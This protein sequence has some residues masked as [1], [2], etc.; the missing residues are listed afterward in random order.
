LLLVD[1]VLHDYMIGIIITSF[2]TLIGEVGQSLS[3]EE[4]HQ[5]RESHYELAF[6]NGLFG[7]LFFLTIVFLVPSHTEIG[8]QFSGLVFNIDSLPT[9]ITRL[10]L[11]I[12]LI[13]LII[14]GLEKA[15][16]A[17]FS[18]L[19]IL[20]IPFLVVADIAL[21]FNISWLEILG[22]GVILTT[23]LTMLST[24]TLRT[25]GAWHVA[26]GSLLA[27]FTI[28]LYQYNITNFNSIAGEQLMMYACLGTYLGI[29]SVY[30]TRKNPLRHLKRPRV[31]I[32][33]ISGG[34][35]SVMISFAF[36]FAPSSI[37]TT[38]KR[39]SAILWAILSGNRFFHEQHIGAKLAGLG[40]LSISL[41]MLAILV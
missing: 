30:T 1:I 8:Q 38:A 29:A 23:V 31:A 16:R 11:E 12:I 28:S 26:G 20:T 32:R 36:L 6:I 2:A 7:I 9:F 25:A 15:S 3:K 4:L 34:L 14:I 21:G 41:I 10:V 22:M 24:R 17:T 40:M 13:H 18:F 35:A 19:R 33:A 39:T 5:R 27:V 37:I